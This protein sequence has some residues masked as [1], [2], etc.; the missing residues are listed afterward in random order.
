MKRFIAIAFLALS[1]CGMLAQKHVTMDLNGLVIG[2]TYTK[3][4]VVAKFGNPVVYRSSECEFGLDECFYYGKDRDSAIELHNDG[5]FNFFSVAEKNMPILT[6]L[7][8]GG[9]RVGENISA[10]KKVGIPYYLESK[11][12]YSMV[13]GP[14]FLYI[15]V[16]EKNIITRFVFIVPN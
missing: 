8:A 9:I 3:K 5:V 16:D 4:Q 6:N 15:Q 10:M 13:F 1:C 7:I 12:E 2:Q 11:G 14:G